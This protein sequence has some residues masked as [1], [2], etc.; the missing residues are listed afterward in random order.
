M[1]YGGEHLGKS[2]LNQLGRQTSAVRA[3]SFSY[4]CRV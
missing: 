3:R 4:G 2:A 1:L